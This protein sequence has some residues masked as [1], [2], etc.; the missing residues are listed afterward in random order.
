MKT[1]QSNTPSPQKNSSSC[2]L[3][4]LIVFI[5]GIVILVGVA[6]AGFIGFRMFEKDITKNLLQKKIGTVTNDTKLSGFAQTFVYPNGAVT[7]IQKDTDYGAAY[8][9]YEETG[10]DLQMVYNY[11]EYLAVI[12]GW[13]L[14]SRGVNTLG[15]GGF[16][17][18]SESDFSADLNYE[19]KKGGKTLITVDIYAEEPR[20]SQAGV[21]PNQTVATST[22]TYGPVRQQPSSTVVKTQTGT[23][24]IPDSNVRKITEADIVGLTPWQLKVARNELY[25]RYGRPFVH[26]DLACYFQKQSWYV[27]D[28][29]FTESRL[30]SLEQNNAVTILNYEKKI[31]SPLLNVDSGCRQ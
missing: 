25:A 2:L 11:Y 29:S 24:I 28:P 16:L 19:Q 5:I 23:F 22:P 6:I 31:Q 10:D 14:G 1:S 27:M 3:I 7:G 8:A 18:L 15:D 20:L 13:E 30:S 4:T 9:L 26:K 12:N 21:I 17:H